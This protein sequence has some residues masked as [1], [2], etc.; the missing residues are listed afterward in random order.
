LQSQAAQVVSTMTSLS[1]TRNPG[2]RAV[3]HAR[4]KGRCQNL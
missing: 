1:N 3:G 2:A 4:R